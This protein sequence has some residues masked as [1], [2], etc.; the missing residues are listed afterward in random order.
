MHGKQSIIQNIFQQSFAIEHSHF[1]EKHYLVKTL[2]KKR[3][4]ICIFY[5]NKVKGF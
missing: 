1:D 2:I 3:G 4:N 5:V